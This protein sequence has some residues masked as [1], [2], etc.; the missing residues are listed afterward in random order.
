MLS[1]DSESCDQACSSLPTKDTATTYL[2]RCDAKYLR[3]VNT[4]QVLLER[5]PGQCTECR[6]EFNSYAPA[7]RWRAP[8]PVVARKG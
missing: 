1:R 2:Y 5:Y 8:E 3:E 6:T 7:V 4:C